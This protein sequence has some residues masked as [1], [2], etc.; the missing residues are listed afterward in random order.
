VRT[1]ALDAL[2][3]RGAVFEHA[4]CQM[5]LCTPSRMCV[6]TGRNVRGCGAWGNGS[7]MRP[8]MPTVASAFA[9]AGYET[10]LMGKMHFGGTRQFNGFRRRPYGDL[11]GQPGHQRDPIT[12][13]G[14]GMQIR[15]RTRDAGVTEIP[16][17]QLQERVV[18][19]ESLS[20]L[21]EHTAA[22]PE[23]P[24]LLCASFSRPHFPLTTPR[25]F[26]DRYDP[27]GVTPPKVG[28]TGDA[29]EHP[30]VRGAKDG[31][32]VAEIGAE[33]EKRA[34][35]AYFG[36]VDQLDEILGEFLQRLERDGLLENT[37]VLYT[38]DHGELA[39]EHGLWWKHTYHEASARVPLMVQLPAHREGTLSPN[40]LQTPVSLGD[41]FPTLCG[42][43]E[44]PAPGDLD[45]VDLSQAIRRG[46]EPADRGPVFCDNLVPRWGAGTEFRM[47]RE[48]RYKYV[49]FRDAPELLF[50][51]EADPREQ[52]NLAASN[53][54]PEAL[55]KLRDLAARTMDFD[56]AERE[57]E[58][59]E[60][61]AENERLPAHARSLNGNVY[62]MPNGELWDAETTLYQPL[63][64]ASD[65]A[66]TFLDWPGE[67]ADA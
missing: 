6:L 30:M 5:P 3:S 40:A 21:R 25:R 19:E 14:N 20:F 54:P 27:D 44:V 59:D 53:E 65:P 38:S 60:A 1:P 23:Q 62:C 52:R 63:V 49:A 50:D 61:R 58:Q 28:P 35:A 18:V 42:L 11:F 9:D 32:R 26:L 36:C 56:A 24:W 31:F 13:E 15:S 67:A 10:C 4:Y 2:A 8:N 46:E 16:E 17:S 66:R 29:A 48:G 45:G 7:V 34:R 55:Q 22:K 51:L 43:C 57:R 47:I 37:I 33:E 41:L 39:G 64:E 12:G